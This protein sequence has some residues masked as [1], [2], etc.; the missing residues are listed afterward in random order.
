MA[1]RTPAV[2]EPK[3][4]D[5]EAQLA[6]LREQANSYRIWWE[7]HQTLLAY[8]C[9]LVTGQAALNRDI[10]PADDHPEGRREV[11]VEDGNA[12]GRWRLAS[13][14]FDSDVAKLFEFLREQTP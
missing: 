6:A 13:Y 1:P 12:P 2:Q 9:N 4:A 11:A 14:G 10:V 7:E 3:A 5:L 8:A